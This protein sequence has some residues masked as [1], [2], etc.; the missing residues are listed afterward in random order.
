M[1]FDS[2]D[3]LQYGSCSSPVERLSEEQSAAGPIPAR[4]T[5]KEFEMTFEEAMNNA[6]KCLKRAGEGY[7][8]AYSNMLVSV[9]QSWI[10][11]ATM[12]A[13]VSALIP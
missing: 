8:V 3:R 11:M 5:K 12:I 4:A 2:S 13:S 10:A 7:D 6:A 9:A 1:R